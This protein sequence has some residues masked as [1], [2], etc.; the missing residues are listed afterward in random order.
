[1][2]SDGFGLEKTIPNKF[3][4]YLSVGKPILCYGSGAVAKK[5]IKNKL[6]YRVNTKNYEIFYNTLKK[7]SKFN[8]AKMKTFYKTNIH[9]FN[10]HY[11]IDENVKKLEVILKKT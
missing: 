8:N 7:I 5:V 9:Y 11:K 4:N 10:K 1:L 2:L 6:G 3:Q